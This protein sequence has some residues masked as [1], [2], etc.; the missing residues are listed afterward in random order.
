VI[1][2]FYRWRRNPLAAKPPIPNL[3]NLSI[4]IS[5]MHYTP[6]TMVCQ[7]FIA[8]NPPI[9][10]NEKVIKCFKTPAKNLERFDNYGNNLYN[11]GI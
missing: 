11:S 4:R 7:T 9:K 5:G 6:K 10:H 3:S 2:R 1:E 8:Q